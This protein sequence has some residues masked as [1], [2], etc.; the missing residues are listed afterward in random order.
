MQDLFYLAVIGLFF[1]VVG[2][3]VRAC[4]RLRAGG[5]SSDA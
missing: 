5:N 2:L 3:Y 1:L 4:E